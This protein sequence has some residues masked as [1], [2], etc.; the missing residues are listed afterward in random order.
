MAEFYSPDMPVDR[1]IGA[2]PEALRNHPKAKRSMHPI[3]SFTGVNASKILDA[4]TLDFP[5]APIE[6]LAAADGWVVLLG[7]NHRT[8]TSIHL[9]EYRAG[10]KT[11]QRWALTR[12]GA[13]ACPNFPPCS[14]GF[15][16]LDALLEPITHKQLVGDAWVRVLPL[17]GLLE[18]AEAEIARNPQALLC[19]R[20]GCPRCDAIRAEL[21]VPA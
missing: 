16:A 4:Q 5:L 1:L 17:R 6:A 21:A 2:V 9:A 18:I 13:A 11:F 19:E 3:L 20:E 15:Q 10:R 7:V 14:D 12:D 8:N